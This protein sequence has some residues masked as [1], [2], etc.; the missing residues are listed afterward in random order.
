[1]RRVARSRVTGLLERMPPILR[2][3]LLFPYTGGP[4]FVQ[5][6]QAQGGWDAVNA[7]FAKPPAS[8]E[9]ILHPEKYDAARRRSTSTSPTTSPRG[10]ARAGR[11]ASRT[12]SASS[13]CSSGWRTLP[14][15]SLARRRRRGRGRLGRRPGRASSTDRRAWA[16]VSRPT[17]TRPPTRPSSRRGDAVVATLA[18]AGEVLAPAGGTRVTVVLASSDHARRPARERSRPG[19]LTPPPRYIDSGAEIPS[20]PSALASV[21]PPR[22]PRAR[23]AATGPAPPG[24]TTWASR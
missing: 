23:R 17:G 13:S 22:P 1:M 24:S 18:G 21:V 4:S 15:A 2:E 9:Q 6:L 12:R 16:V 10:S 11:S 7:A 19:R 20:R 3:S 5:R 14:A 8:T